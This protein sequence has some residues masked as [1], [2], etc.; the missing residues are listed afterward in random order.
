MNSRVVVVVIASAVVVAASAAYLVYRVGEQRAIAATAPAPDTVT[1]LAAIGDVP[2]IVFRSTSL[3]ANYGRVAVVDL[4][5]PAGP[6]A[7][8]DT[9]C[10]RVFATATAGL[11]LAA[12]RGAVTTYKTFVL[13]ADFEVARELPLTGLPSRARLSPDGALAATTTFVTGH[14]YL[15]VGFSTET[16]VSRAAGDSYGNIEDFEL[17]VDGERNTAADRNIWG[18]T[19]ADD[20]AFY[21]TAASGGTTWLVH[22]SLSERRLDTIRT[23]A[24]CPSLSPDGTRIVYKKRSGAPA[25]QWRLAVYD[26]A[27]GTE[28]MLAED[29]SV[30]DQVEWLDDGRIV[31]GLPRSGSEAAVTD[32]W[33]LDLDDDSPAEVL[34]PE[35]WSPAVIR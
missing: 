16:V 15:S 28:R 7:V 6:R 30:D 4:A 13:T 11:C 3:D 34:V 18:V 19:F 31:Y 5:D 24:E 1:D 35:A 20:D 27:G 9:S 12:D 29:R 25:G 14:S 22:G 32:I 23:D 17:Y 10:E 33:Q 2:R 8:T 21:A 26:I